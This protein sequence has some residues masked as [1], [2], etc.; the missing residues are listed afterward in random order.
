MVMREREKEGDDAKEQ[1][2]EQKEW[3]GTAGSQEPNGKERGE[4]GSLLT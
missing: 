1:Q 3:C 4:G 2:P